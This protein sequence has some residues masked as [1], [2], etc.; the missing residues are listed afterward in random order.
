[1]DFFHGHR[2]VDIVP[3]GAGLERGAARTRRRRTY[4][5]LDYRRLDRQRPK[6]ITV[7][8]LPHAG[9]ARHCHCQRRARS[10]NIE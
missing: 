5:W 1:M 3:R 6:A 2:F 8:A 9:T 7:P 4:A 10:A